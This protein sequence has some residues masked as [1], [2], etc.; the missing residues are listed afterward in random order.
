MLIFKLN[1][2]SKRPQLSN[3][4]SNQKKNARIICCVWNL[5]TAVV[6]VLELFNLSGIKAKFPRRVNNGRLRAKQNICRLYWTSS[7]WFRICIACLYLRT[8]LCLYT[9]E[10]H[11]VYQSPFLHT[12]AHNI[13]LERKMC[14]INWFQIFLNKCKILSKA[15]VHFNRGKDRIC[16]LITQ[17][18]SIYS[19][20]S[21]WWLLHRISGIL[22]QW[23]LQV[24]HHSPSV[25]KVYSSLIIH[26]QSMW[27]LKLSWQFI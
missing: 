7:S 3:C 4:A 19:L 11:Y 6:H 1:H 14:I 24:L 23:Y 26:H 20:P 9:H 22:N 2:V 15:F 13:L 27:L 5:K 10:P 17:R 18:C 25:D 8:Y 12:C 21:T 16:Y